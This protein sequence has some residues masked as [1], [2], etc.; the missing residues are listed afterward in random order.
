MALS[1]FKQK[2]KTKRLKEIGFFDHDMSRNLQKNSIYSSFNEFQKKSTKNTM[3][4][5][6]EMPTSPSSALH[7]DYACD[8]LSLFKQLSQS[9]A[10]FVI[11]YTIRDVI[12]S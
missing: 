10:D 5:L 1:R 12:K 3:Q 6:S 9:Y 8:G 7:R 4:K 11:G 2:M